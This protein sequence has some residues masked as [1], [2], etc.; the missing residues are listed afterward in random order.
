[1]NIFLKKIRFITI[2]LAGILIIFFLFQPVEA[3]NYKPLVTIPGVT[4]AEK[5]V[6][7]GSYLQGLYQLFYAVAAVT[8][9]VLIIVGGFQYMST[10]AIFDK[11]EGKDRIRRAV[12]GFLMVLSSWLILYT[13]NPELAKFEINFALDDNTPPGYRPAPGSGC[14]SSHDQPTVPGVYLKEQF[15][16]P[17]TCR[18]SNGAWIVDTY[19]RY[20]RQ[21][22]EQICRDS[23]QSSRAPT[24]SCVTITENVRDG[25]QYCYKARSYVGWRHSSVLGVKNMGR[26]EPI[27]SNPQEFCGESDS[28]ETAARNSCVARRNTAVTEVVRYGEVWYA[29][30]S[31]ATGTAYKY[32][33]TENCYIK[34]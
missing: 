32:I 22:N 5:P 8:A 19:T 30:D 26:P 29:P 18:D 24:K 1:M 28:N 14:V 3:Q 23:I 33:I 17:E 31:L 4:E 11:K 12:L 9:I 20:S 10:D 25:Y 15:T 21:G 34:L 13:I 16:Q 6:D 7:L 2:L 27:Y